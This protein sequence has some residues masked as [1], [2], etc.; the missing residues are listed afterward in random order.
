[1][2]GNYIKWDHGQQGKVIFEVYHGWD[3]IVYRE[4]DI[5]DLPLT[6]RNGAAHYKDCG[7][8]FIER[9]EE[10][11][12]SLTVESNTSTWSNNNARISNCQVPFK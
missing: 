7:S 10:Y 11:Y 12:A 6:G 9:S 3:L 2:W 1:M 4:I 5:A 8:V